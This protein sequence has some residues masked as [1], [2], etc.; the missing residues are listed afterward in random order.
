MVKLHRSVDTIGGQL[1]G[2]AISIGNFDGV[3]RGHVALLAELRMLANELGGP[4]IAVTFDPSPASILRPDKAPPQLTTLSRRSDLL[5]SCG[6]DDVVVCHTD[7]K[8]LSQSPE[9]FFQ[10]L[11]IEQ[12]AAKGMVEGPNFYFGK[13]RAGDIRALEKLCAEHKMRLRIALPQGDGQGLVSSTRIR[14]QLA[15]GEVKLANESLTQPYRLAGQVARGAARGRQLGFPTA[16]LEQIETMI[17]GPGVYACRARLESGSVLVAATHIGPNPTFA[18]SEI[19]VEVHLLDFSGDLY[20]QKLEVEFVTR[21]RGVMRF[22]SSAELIEQLQLDI[23]QT[24][25]EI[26]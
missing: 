3:H 26:S 12:L 25:R 16:N 21:V 5:L 20:D 7:A 24:R 1:R 10:Q 13:Q 11:V 19:K 8:L 22:S 18:D 2:G 17:P 6:V 23:A 14:E 9:Q 15:A 4:A